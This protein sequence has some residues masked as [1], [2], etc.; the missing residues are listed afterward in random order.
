[1]LSNC[2][3]DSLINKQLGFQPEIKIQNLEVKNFIKENIGEQ[4][5]EDVE[6]LTRLLSIERGCAQKWAKE[7]GAIAQVVINRVNTPSRWGE[8][9]KEVVAKNGGKSWFGVS[10]EKINDPLRGIDGKESYKGCL[11]SALNF[12][13][14][15][16][17]ED[18]GAKE[19]GG[20]TGF[21][22]RCTQVKEGRE[23]PDWN[24]KNPLQVQSET[25]AAYFS[26]DDISNKDCSLRKYKLSIT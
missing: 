9:S 15:K 3:P 18:L 22:H 20:R 4:Y 23:V 10:N 7:R 11:Q 24:Y 26:G 1:M 17:Q 25:C 14:C 8:N 6:Y 16:G 12:M 19:I 2:N 21:V 5:L 13:M